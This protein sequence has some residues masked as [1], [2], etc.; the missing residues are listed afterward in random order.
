MC[1]LTIMSSFPMAQHGLKIV[2]NLTARLKNVNNCLSTNFYSYLVTPG[3]YNFNKIFI[4]CLFF[5]HQC[6]YTFPAA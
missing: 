6:F 1:F 5:Q 2:N 3:G 4:F